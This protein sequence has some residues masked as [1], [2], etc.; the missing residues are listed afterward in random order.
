MNLYTLHKLIIELLILGVHDT[1]SS[2]FIDLEND[3]ET[4][5]H[6]IYC[7]LFFWVLTF[8]VFVIRLVPRKLRL[9]LWNH[10]VSRRIN[11]YDFCFWSVFQGFV[12]LYICVPH[13]TYSG[14]DV[15]TIRH[16]GWFP[17]VDAQKS[18]DFRIDWINDQPFFIFSKAT[19]IHNS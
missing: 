19:C 2:S 10:K 9:N 13:F 17:R 11:E 15:I 7:V 18:I 8:L 6:C 12:T 4:L 1:S 3:S 16:H 5:C 14:N